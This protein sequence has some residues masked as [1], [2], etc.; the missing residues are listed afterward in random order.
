MR[1]PKQFDLFL[2]PTATPLTSVS[3]VRT[4]VVPLLCALLL[5]VMAQQHSQPNTA[6]K[7]LNHEQQDHA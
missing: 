1:R 5:E 4:K 6:E 3:A 2:V 7:D